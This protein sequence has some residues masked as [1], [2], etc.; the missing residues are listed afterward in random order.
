MKYLVDLEKKEI[1]YDKEMPA[2]HMIAL[3]KIF[4][5]KGYEFVQNDVIETVEET[6]KK[7]SG[8]GSVFN[9]MKGGARYSAVDYARE[10]IT[11]KE[12]M[13]HQQKLQQE[14]MRHNAMS[15]NFYSP[16]GRVHGSQAEMENYMKTNTYKE[17]VFFN[18]DVGFEFKEEEPI[19][20]KEANKLH[21]EAQEAV[22]FKDKMQNLKTLLGK[23]NIF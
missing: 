2:G 11:Q 9:S 13:L 18:E 22:S 19:S 1:Q 17:R 3:R 23:I 20:A 14:Q 10:Q 4:K 6:D 15:G 12:Q 7:L 8:Y 21:Q 5:D 16:D